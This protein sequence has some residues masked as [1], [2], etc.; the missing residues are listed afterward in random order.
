MKSYAQ[1]SVCKDKFVQSY[2]GTHGSIRSKRNK[3]FCYVD[4][5]LANGYRYIVAGRGGGGNNRVN[6][7]N[8]DGRIN[9]RLLK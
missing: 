2:I 7:G 8:K 3:A 6:R 4:R 5:I 9:V 1:W